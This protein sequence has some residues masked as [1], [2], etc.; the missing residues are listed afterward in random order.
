VSS[1][2]AIAS[3]RLEISRSVQWHLHPLNQ[4]LQLTP[5]L[6]QREWSHAYDAIGNATVLCHVITAFR[7]LEVE[8]PH[9]KISEFFVFCSDIVKEMS[10]YCPNPNYAAI[11]RSSIKKIERTA[12]KISVPSEDS[13][14]FAGVTIYSDVA[15]GLES[16]EHAIT[17]LQ[18]AHSASG[19]SIAGLAL[20]LVWVGHEDDSAKLRA[21]SIHIFAMHQLA[22]QIRRSLVSV[23][24][25]AAA[26]A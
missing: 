18:E 10:D 3:K 13:S 16:L 7:T 19:G 6:S 15:G 22:G 2:P 1:N 11:G 14:S 12:G 21:T 9:N 26:Q 23:K 8:I 24:K 25:E 17:A 20:D 4:D 5:H